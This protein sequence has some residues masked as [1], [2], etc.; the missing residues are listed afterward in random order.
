MLDPTIHAP[1]MQRRQNRKDSTTQGTVFKNSV[2][3]KGKN[4]TVK[5]GL[6]FAVLSQEDL[7]EYGN[8]SNGEKDQSNE[9]SNDQKEPGKESR[10]S[11]SGKT[12]AGQNKPN[13]EKAKTG[14][15]TMPKS[16]S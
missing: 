7:E 11:N 3:S 14:P 9:A 12:Q 15:S 13:Q 5:L 2:D 6:R 8:V 1:Q 10:A 16:P 4:N